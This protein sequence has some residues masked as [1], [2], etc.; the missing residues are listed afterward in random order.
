MA[1]SRLPPPNRRARLRPP[2][3]R[4]PL[5]TLPPGRRGPKVARGASLP[6]QGQ[7]GLPQVMQP[8]RLPL[9]GI[10]LLLEANLL[11]RWIRLLGLNPPKAP[12]TA[13]PG[14]RPPRPPRPLPPRAHRPPPFRWLG[15]YQLL[16]GLPAHPPVL[17]RPPANPQLAHLGGLPRPRVVELPRQYGSASLL[18]GEGCALRVGSLGEEAETASNASC[19]CRRPPQCF[20]RL[21]PCLLVGSLPN[22]WGPAQRRPR[23]KR[24]R[25]LEPVG[26]PLSWGPGSRLH[27]LPPVNLAGR[28]LG[29]LIRPPLRPRNLPPPWIWRFW[30]ARP[31]ALPPRTRLCPPPP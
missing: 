4:P 17:R 26:T 11:S 31:W 24:G 14:G 19:P 13:L 30:W 22:L 1:K 23:R 10:P 12:T 6:C 9:L 2:P 5:P 7:V 15:R 16:P 25:G 28:P 3:R 20:H 29:W 27:L 21:R 18:A 8:S